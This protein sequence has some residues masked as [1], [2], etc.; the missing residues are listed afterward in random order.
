[1]NHVNVV[2]K[3]IFHGI[4]DDEMNDA[5]DMIWSEYTSFNYKKGPFGGGGFIQ[6][7]KDIL[8]GDSHVLYQNYSLP[9]TK[10]LVSVACRVTSC[11]IFLG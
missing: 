7:I 8:E 6:N 10:V 5:L 4:S 11:C 9:F 1:M 2:I 3:E